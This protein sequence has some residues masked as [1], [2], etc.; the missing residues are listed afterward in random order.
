MVILVLDGRVK[1]SG[2]AADIWAMGVTLYSFVYGKVTFNF[3]HYFFNKSIY[4]CTFRLVVTIADCQKYQLLHLRNLLV[5]YI[6]L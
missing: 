5:L 6:P 1:F 4:F 3:T 2:K